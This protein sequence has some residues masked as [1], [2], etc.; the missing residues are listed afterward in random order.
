MSTSAFLPLKVLYV[1]DDELAR[2]IIGR[3]LQKTV[4]NIYLGAN[5]AEGLELF[6][7]HEPD[8]VI[9]DVNMPIMD[10]R[11]MLRQI[12]TLKPDIP[13]IVTTA[14][15]DEDHRAGDDCIVLVKPVFREKLIEA[16][17]ELSD[18]PPSE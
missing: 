14:Y 9:T 5:G 1:E 4:S 2:M 10:G 13:V 7:Q 18:L 6:K 8:I 15:E 11:E 3:W 17:R 12:K 16:I